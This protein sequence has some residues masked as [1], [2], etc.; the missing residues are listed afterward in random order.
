MVRSEIALLYRSNAQSRVMETA[1][2]NAGVSLPSTAAPGG[3]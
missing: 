2:F 1:L 3:F